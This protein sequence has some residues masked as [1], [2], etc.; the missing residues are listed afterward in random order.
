MPSRR[1]VLAGL[2]SFIVSGSFLTQGFTWPIYIL[3]GLSLSVSSFANRMAAGEVTDE[4]DE[5]QQPVKQPDLARGLQDRA[6]DGMSQ[7]ATRDKRRH[8]GRCW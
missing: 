1:P 4:D 2:A 8:G 6:R 3:L 7:E 5:L